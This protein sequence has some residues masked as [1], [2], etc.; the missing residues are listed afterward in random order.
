MGETDENS[1]APL[2]PF[3]PPSPEELDVA[4]GEPYQIH[5]LIGRGGMGAVYQ[6][7]QVSLNRNVAIK[8]LPV[9]RLTFDESS[10]GFSL[11]ERFRREAEAMARLNHPNI[12]TVHDFGEVKGDVLY[13]A[14]ELVDGTDLNSALRG[15]QVDLE[16]TFE[17]LVQICD[18]LSY[19]HAQGMVHRD[20]K[21]ANILIAKDGR[22]KVADF[23]LVKVVGHDSLISLHTNSPVGSP[24]FTAPEVCENDGDVDHRADLYSLGV[25]IY[26]LF[27]GRYPKGVWEP[28]SVQNPDLDPR[29]DALVEKALK[30]DPSQR[31]QSAAEMR[32]DL[33]QIINASCH[34]ERLERDSSLV[35]S[36]TDSHPLS[37]WEKDGRPFLDRCMDG[38][39]VPTTHPCR[40]SHLIST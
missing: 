39:G 33:L 36:S 3:Q 27:T 8:I 24:E 40:R 29:L 16:K 15:G 13:F 26:L 34:Q 7:R 6:A 22:I 20:I 23:G 31:Y 11:E 38:I 10:S 19:A 37:A 9:A 5:H 30:G 25:V 17:W 18:A 1:S 12:V 14:M 35:S 28:P 21:P 32:R 2:P 4:I